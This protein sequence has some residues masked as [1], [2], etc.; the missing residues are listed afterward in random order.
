MSFKAVLKK[1]LSHKILIVLL[2]IS[3]LFVGIFIVH[4]NQYDTYTLEAD[5]LVIVG[6]DLKGYSADVI[7]YDP[8]SEVYKNIYDS[9]YL[10]NKEMKALEVVDIVLKDKAGN[11]VAGEIDVQVKFKVDENIENVIGDYILWDKDYIINKS[12]IFHDGFVEYNTNQLGKTI[13][14]KVGSDEYD[15]QS[16]IDT[17][18]KDD[19]L[20]I[21]KAKISP[22]E[23]KKYTG[24]AITPLVSVT[25]DSNTLKEDVDYIISYSNNTNIG[26]AKVKIEGIGKYEGSVNLTFKIIEDKMKKENKETKVKKV[27]IENAKISLIKDQKYTGKAITPL[28]TV[29]LNGKI[30]KKEIDYTVSYSNNINAGQAKII[31]R[32][33][34]NYKGSISSTFTIIRQKSNDYKTIVLNKVTTCHGFKGYFTKD[35]NELNLIF[36]ELGLASD[37]FVY[38]IMVT[39]YYD[40]D[41]GEIIFFAIP[42]V[43]VPWKFDNLVD[44]AGGYESVPVKVK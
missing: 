17:N 24:K 8:K 22:I 35:R 37:N 14:T 44:D 18:H 42:E 30:L 31:V 25:M 10:K 15:N 6:K 5:G 28:I 4:I 41:T 23:D 39:E 34:G 33:K 11:E 21:A 2:G 43:I 36:D 19:K 27:S 38:S 7:R 13:I 26:T 16:D 32:G 29:S 3:L 1:I 12:A 40:V 20:S 9:I